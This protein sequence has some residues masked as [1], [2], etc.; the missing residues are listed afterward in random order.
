MKE[1]MYWSSSEGDAWFSWGVDF[2]S[3]GVSNW[4]YKYYDLYVRPC[5]AFELGV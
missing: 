2:G 1:E 3:G 4:S 5:T